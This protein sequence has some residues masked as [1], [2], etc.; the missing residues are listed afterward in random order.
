MK[1]PKL[2]FVTGAMATVIAATLIT[3]CAT[4]HEAVSYAQT[5]PKMKMTTPI[6][7]QII[8]PEKGRD[9][10]RHAEFPRRFSGRMPPWKK[11]MSILDFMHGVEAFLYAMPGASAHAFSIGVKSMGADNQTIL[12]TEELLDSKSLFLT[13][14]TETIYNMT[15]LDLKKGPLVVEVPPNILGHG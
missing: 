12:I 4:K 14:N 2:T 15:W 7:S 10:P 11:S 3:G 13:A 8:T 6:P 1:T 9:A 5:P